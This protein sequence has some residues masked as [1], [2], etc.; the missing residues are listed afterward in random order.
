MFAGQS[1]QE[2]AIERPDLGRPVIDAGNTLRH[3]GV[4]VV[5]DATRRLLVAEENRLPGGIRQGGRQSFVECHVP[6]R[7]QIPGDQAHTIN[8]GQFGHRLGQFQPV[9]P[10]VRLRQSGGQQH[11]LGRIRRSVL[12]R[13]DQ[14]TQAADGQQVTDEP[15]ACSVPGEQHRATGRHQVLFLDPVQA[16]HGQV[17]SS[18]GHALRP[19]HLHVVGLAGS[20]QPYGDRLQAL[21]RPRIGRQRAGADRPATDTRQDLVAQPRSVG[22]FAV[23]PLLLSRKRHREKLEPTTAG[24][25][26]QRGPVG[27]HAD[28]RRSTGMIQCNRGP[29]R[30]RFVL[31]RIGNLD[32]SCVLQVVG[33]PPR[34]PATGPDQQLEPTVTADIGQGHSRCSLADRSPGALEF[35]SLAGPAPVECPLPPGQL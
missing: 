1:S 28:D 30:Q 12:A 9:P 20:T 17:E 19:D 10:V 3:V 26:R 32:Q 23:P 24:G 18:L 21:A 11:V 16:A 34:R 5:G 22:A 29:G 8:V 25:P 33:H 7:R 35:Q 13:R 15:I 14:V 4:A 27:Q 31:A 2:P 6:S